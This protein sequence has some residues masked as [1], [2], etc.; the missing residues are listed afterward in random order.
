MEGIGE[1]HSFREPVECLCDIAGI[2]SFYTGQAE[3][4][5]KSLMHYFSGEIIT[6]RRR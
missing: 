6:G 4:M 2:F 3:N 1:V 5:E